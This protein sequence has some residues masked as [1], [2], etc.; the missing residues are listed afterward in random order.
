MLAAR[1]AKDDE[2]SLSDAA[3][4]LEAELDSF[5]ALAASLR[6]LP[7]GSKKN[8]ERA[9]RALQE[10]AGY[11]ERLAGRLHGLVAAINVASRRQ[12]ESAAGIVERGREIE[13]RGAEYRE[14]LARFAALGGEAQEL[15]VL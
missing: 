11:E 12:Q 2:P 3:A 6:K 14:V 15:T 1:M 13:A 5:E 9:A 10:A 7:L 4:A 8:L